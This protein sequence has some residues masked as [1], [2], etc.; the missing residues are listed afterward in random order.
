METVLPKRKSHHLTG[1]TITAQNGAYF[2]TICTHQRQKMLWDSNAS[3][4]AEAPVG[5]SIAYPPACARAR[6]PEDHRPISGGPVPLFCGDAQSIIHAFRSRIDTVTG[7]S[8]A[9]AA[10]IISIVQSV[11]PTV[12]STVATVHPVSCQARGKP[13]RS[14]STLSGKVP[15]TTTSS[16]MKPDYSHD[17]GN[18]FDTNPRLWHKDCFYEEP[19]HEP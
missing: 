15:F 19:S 18:T 8:C 4:E 1:V 6:F 12:I 7:G 13:H 2:I 16:A 11:R 14:I 5:A 3:T 10:T 9:S 17:C